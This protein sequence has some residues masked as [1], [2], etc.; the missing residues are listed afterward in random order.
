VLMGPDNQSIQIST[1]DANKTLNALISQRYDVQSGAAPNV[2]TSQQMQYVQIEGLSLNA[3]EQLLLWTD[4]ALEQVGVSNT[5]AA[6]NFNVTISTAD[7]ATGKVV[8]SQQ[9]AGGVAA[10]S[11]FVAITNWQQIAAPAIKQGALGALLP[12]SFQ[13][14]VV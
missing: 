1:S 5:G 12:A 11:D 4:A 9:V 10:N 8:A 6:K 3:G 2:K 14:P 7:P 13:K